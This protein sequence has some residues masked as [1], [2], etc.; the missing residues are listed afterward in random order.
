MLKMTLIPATG[1]S[2][3]RLVKSFGPHYLCLSL[4]PRN[5]ADGLVDKAVALALGLPGS[6]PGPR[7]QSLAF[8]CCACNSLIRYNHSKLNGFGLLKIFH[9]HSPLKS[10]RCLHSPV[11][12]LLYL[13]L[14]LSS[15]VVGLVKSSTNMCV[16]HVKYTERRKDSFAFSDARQRELFCQLVTHMKRAHCADPE[17]DVVSL[18]VGTWNMAEEIPSWSLVPWLKSIGQGKTRD[19][20]LTTIP[21]DV[22]VIG[23]QESANTEREWERCLKMFLEQ[24]F[25]IRFE[26]VRRRLGE[27]M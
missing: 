3:S 10:K 4:K 1:T 23:T 26:T 6:I 9:D 21:H 25:H 22:Y 11:R 16:L 19:L 7:P 13:F 15:A 20:P 8:T 18:F 2:A 24:A 12:P 17:P 5:R 27:R 14:T